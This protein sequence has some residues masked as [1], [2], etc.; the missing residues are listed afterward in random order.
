MK[1]YGRVIQDGVTQ[2]DGFQHSYPVPPPWADPNQ[3]ATYLDAKIAIL[4]A[5]LESVGYE[6]TFSDK[7]ELFDQQGYLTPENGYIHLDK[8]QKAKD[9]GTF[10]A[11]RNKN[12][13]AEILA[14]QERTGHENWCGCERCCHD[15]DCHVCD[16]LLTGLKNAREGEGVL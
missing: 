6:V 13:T 1:L 12:T 8:A 10:V 2:P 4:N 14:Y 16:Q 15:E 11:E 7:P 9:R 3:V 5:A